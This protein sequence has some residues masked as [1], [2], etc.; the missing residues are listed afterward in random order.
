MELNP[1]LESV[2]RGVDDAT[3]LADDTTRDIAARLLTALDTA[4]RLALIDALADAAAEISGDLAPGS[5]ELR[6]DAGSPHFVV[7]KPAPPAPNDLSDYARTTAMPTEEPPTDRAET[8]LLGDEDDEPTA[9][10]SFRVPVS[11][12]A[13]IDEKAG[14]DGL[15]AN[16]WL[17]RTV[18]HALDGRSAPGGPGTQIFGPGG[19]F[20][21]GGSIE[22]VMDTFGPNGSFSV[23]SGRSRSRKGRG[24]RMQGWAQ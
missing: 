11:V 16:A 23:D 18:M 8:Q 9:R 4:T 13:R 2:R 14:A 24:Q 6:M 15:S 5:V 10:I 3:A 1:Y 22:R 7:T 21:P 19:P 20:G 17:L 12:K